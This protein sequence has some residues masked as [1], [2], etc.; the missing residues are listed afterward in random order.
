MV[1]GRHRGKDVC[2]AFG[3][4]CTIDKEKRIPRNLKLGPFWELIS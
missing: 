3:G 2:F 1:M 4:M